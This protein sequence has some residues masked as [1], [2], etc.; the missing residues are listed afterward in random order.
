MR[1]HLT[2]LAAGLAV[3]ARAVSAQVAAAP[4]AAD[5]APR[6]NTVT[7]QN[8]RKVP[9]TVYLDYG[10]FDRRLGVVA[11]LRTQVLA[12]PAWAAR[13]R[14]S[15]QLVAHPEGAWQDLASQTFTLHPPA[16]LGM[17]VPPAGAALASRQTPQDTMTAVIPPEELAD[18][19]I[20]VEN[21]RSR[22]VT[23]YADQDDFDVRLGQVP[24]RGRAT[25]VFPKSV[26]WPDG[27]LRVFVHPD[28][29]ADLASQA[30][31]VRAGDHLGLRVPAR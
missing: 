26:I 31:P 16:R 27:S 14:T 10:P 28:G 17:L 29:G 4:A 8:D 6:A 18:A 5:S 25:L 23:V 22:A 9:V 12:L 24:A 21:P 15:V 11:P 13:G 2:P 3:L 30:M 1:T 7:V 20:T 19:T